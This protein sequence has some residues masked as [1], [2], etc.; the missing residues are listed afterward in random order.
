[1]TDVNSLSE[2][3][4]N[5]YAS[6]VAMSAVESL[7]VQPT[8]LIQYRSSGRVAVIGS[9]EAQEF[10][11][12]LS[13]NLHAQI[14]LTDGAVEPGVPTVPVGNRLLQI[15]GYLG[16][17]NIYL[18]E[19]GKA[20]FE[21][22][23]VDL[24][25][26][27]CAEPLL[28]M[29]LKPPGYLISK[30]EEPYLTL[31]EEE[32][33]D[34]TGTFEKPKY[35]DYDASIC[36][37]GRSGVA[38][39]TKCIDACP[40][41]AITTLI[42]SIEVNPNLCQGGGVCT[43]VCPTGAIRYVYPNVTD[44]LHIVSTLL[45]RYCDA[46]GRDP[47]IAF[48]AEAETALLET[49]LDNNKPDNLLVVVVE[50]LA[51]VGMEVWLSALASGAKSVLLMDAGSMPE[52]VGGFLQ[53][54][55]DTANSILSGLG[56]KE[57]LIRIVAPQSLQQHCEAGESIQLIDE[58]LEEGKFSALLDKH[59]VEKRMNNGF[60]KRGE[61]R[62]TTLLATDFLYQHSSSPQQIIALPEQSPFGRIMVDADACTLCMSCTSV[63]PTQAISAGDDVPKLTFREIK[64]VQ[65]GICESA[66]PERAISL[67]PRLIADAKQ[68]RG[69]VTLHEELPFCCI[70]CGK[71]FATKSMID[72]MTQKLTGH[73]M[74][75]SE[76][77]KLRLMMCEQC[78]VIDV[79]QDNEAMHSV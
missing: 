8:S 30:L 72:N 25:V 62:R 50:E 51:S 22:V 6:K 38:G 66:C 79:V 60:D 31:V 24:I 54:Q 73:Y 49:K 5:A 55:I 78:R 23:C 21:K 41:Q 70:T 18:G 10:A 2:E 7:D 36:A 27:L 11:S 3:T 16:N 76:R 42:N 34:L 32:L 46:G 59:L 45:S 69:S 68:R 52:S 65:C 40:A 53:S 13:G 4:P 74:F 67:E 1:M 43:S 58:T 20:N 56:Y 48:V 47:V 57:S 39:C 77:A 37:H 71:A 14:I 29:P 64:C 15:E 12:R 35:F 63:C 17:F 44:T 26:D 28:S 9:I 33:K 19:E 75:K 61:K